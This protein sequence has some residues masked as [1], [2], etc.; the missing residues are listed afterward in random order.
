[1]LRFL[2]RTSGE[3]NITADEEIESNSS[4]KNEID[5]LT[6]GMQIEQKMR[7][8]EEEVQGD[9]IPTNQGTN[10]HDDKDV[11]SVTH[12]NIGGETVRIE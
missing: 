6:I 9:P 10:R 1:M 8:P 5:P 3:K 11:S 7:I 4:A 12:T 2:K